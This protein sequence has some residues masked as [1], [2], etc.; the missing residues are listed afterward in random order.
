VSTTNDRP[1]L[2]DVY[3][4]DVASATAADASNG[5]LCAFTLEA[6][7]EAGTFARIA[8]VLNIANVAPN[9]VTLDLNKD[10]GTLTVYIE[11][12]VGQSTAQSIQRKLAQLTDVIRVDLR[13]PRMGDGM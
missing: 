4:G 8:G 3:A 11:L 10:H 12:R 6:D 7:A 5:T 1:A 9:R 2:A 13:T